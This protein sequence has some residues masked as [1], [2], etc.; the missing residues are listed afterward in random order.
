MLRPH[1]RAELGFEYINEI[2]QHGQNSR[3]YIAQDHQLG[4]E[5]VIK[6]LAKAHLDAARYFGE[7]QSLYASSH[8]NV[9]Q[10]H[11]ACED[12][13]HVYVAM[14]FYK[15]GSIKDLLAARFLTVR[16]IV[17][18]SCQVL[19]GLQH[20]HSKRLVHFDVK[21]DNVLLSDRGEALLSDFGL[22]RPLGPGGVAEQD[23]FYLKIQPPEGFGGVAFPRTYDIYQIGLLLYRMCNGNEEFYRQFDVFRPGGVFDRNAYRVAVVN[24]QF[25]NRQTFLPHIPERLRRVIRKCLE[26]DPSNRYSSALEVANGLAD[27]QG[28]T[29]DWQY[30]RKADGDRWEKRSND[31]LYE[32]ERADN[33]ST[34]CYKTRDGGARRRV[35]D[36]C[37]QAMTDRQV[38]TFLGDT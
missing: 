13:D 30:S 12:N 32:F 22:A 16:E 25:P 33:R 19:A 37:Q 23:V 2:G 24:G 3:T 6:E 17:T 18:L 5:I 27:I 34:T 26:T 36:G 15:K 35:G 9:V 11:Y 21:P 1:R 38:R 8:P 14:P 4:A 20:V 31:V 10:V 29:L 7:A 28:A